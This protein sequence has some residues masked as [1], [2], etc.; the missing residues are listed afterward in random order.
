MQ[1]SETRADGKTA[2]A[3]QNLLDTNARCGTKRCPARRAFGDWAT[4]REL[5]AGLFVGEQYQGSA[6]DEVVCRLHRVRGDRRC[7]SRAGRGRGLRRPGPASI[8]VLRLHRSGPQVPTGCARG[9]GG[10][11]RHPGGRTVLRRRLAGLPPTSLVPRVPEPARLCVPR[12]E[13]FLLARL[14]GAAECPGTICCGL[15]APGAGPRAVRR[16]RL[17]GRRRVRPAAADGG[18]R[19]AH[20][21]GHTRTSFAAG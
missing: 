16:H 2:P 10:R 12:R 6:H 7:S 11:P 15:Q 21:R 3:C 18:S 4:P 19:Q 17:L 14:Q 5:V 20:C 13:G 8:Q 1:A 9:P